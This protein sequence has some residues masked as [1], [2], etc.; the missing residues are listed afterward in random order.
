VIAGP[1]RVGN[2]LPAIGLSVNPALSHS[3]IIGAVDHAHL[4][5]ILGNAINAGLSRMFM[6]VDDTGKAQLLRRPGQALAVVTVGSAGEG[7]VTQLL[8][9]VVGHQLHKRKTR[10]AQ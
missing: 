6:Y 8:P 3:V 4:S 9:G 5:A 2:D 10:L 1:G 7:K